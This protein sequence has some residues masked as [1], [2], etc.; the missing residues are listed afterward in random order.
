VREPDAMRR[1][2]DAAWDGVTDDGDED[3]TDILICFGEPGWDRTNDLLIK[4][5]LLYH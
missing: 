4:S 2:S 1:N 3:E 5:Q